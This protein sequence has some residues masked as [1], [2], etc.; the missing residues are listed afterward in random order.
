MERLTDFS[1]LLKLKEAAVT[2]FKK[3]IQNF[4]TQWD[5]SLVR[6]VWLY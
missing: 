1:D 6:V 3:Y 4:V 2:H 5:V